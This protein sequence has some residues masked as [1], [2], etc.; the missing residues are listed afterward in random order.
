[1]LKSTREIDKES[2]VKCLQGMTQLTDVYSKPIQE[3][4]GVEQL[5]AILRSNTTNMNNSSITKSQQIL[6]LNTL[7]VLCNISDKYFIRKNLSKITDITTILSKLIEPTW[8]GDIQSRATIL[9]AD[10]S[11]VS[12][13]IKTTFEEKGCCEKLARLLQSE[14]EDLLV[15]TI[16][17]IE[18]LSQN[19]ETNKNKFARMNILVSLCEL[20]MLKSGISTKHFPNLLNF[21]KLLELVQAASAAAIS[22]I[23]I[24]NK[25]NQFLALEQGVPRA[26]TSLLKIRN[27][28][29]QFNIALALESLAKNNDI[30]CRF[31]I[32][33]GAGEGMI[34]LL[35][36]GLKLIFNNLF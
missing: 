24:N 4:S 25:N 5:V 10:I 14:A 22:S 16:N 30:L 23:V 29:V 12:L 1:M 28:T 34:N 11:A 13:S 19:N 26:L 7:S 8:N 17:A 32:E 9:I 18:S 21:V 20:L 31:L 36:V 15:N 6:I 27:V 2:A 35:T 33:M 3:A